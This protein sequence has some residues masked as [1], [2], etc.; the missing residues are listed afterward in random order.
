[1][2]CLLISLISLSTLLL[3]VSGQFPT[4]SPSYSFQGVL[5]TSANGVPSTP[6]DYSLSVDISRG[7]ELVNGVV[8]SNGGVDTFIT[9]YSENDNA[10]YFAENSVCNETAFIPNPLFPVN[11]N[12]WDLYAA[13]TESPAGTYTFTQGDVTQQVVI[14]NGTLVSFMFSFGISEIAVT[15]SNF[16]NTTPDFST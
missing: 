15:V 13:G 12:V 3:A 5:T 11:T 8:A 16:D 7:L 1:M 14:V 9:L 4:L 6:G 2:K 10:V